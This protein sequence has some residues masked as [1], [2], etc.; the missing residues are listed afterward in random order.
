MAS[1]SN[2]L[3]VSFE[4][5]HINAYNGVDHFAQFTQPL[6]TFTKRKDLKLNLKQ[7]QI[8]IIAIIKL[9]SIIM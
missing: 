7:L 6:T 4:G 3:K 5:G 8:Q 1:K 9:K 2:N